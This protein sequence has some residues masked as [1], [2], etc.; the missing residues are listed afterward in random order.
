MMRM[1]LR[2]EGLQRGRWVRIAVLGVLFGLWSFIT[3][4]GAE[5]TETFCELEGLTV[6]AM[7]APEAADGIVAA[8]PADDVLVL[9]VTPDTRAVRLPAPDA[10]GATAPLPGILIA[11]VRPDPPDPDPPSPPPPPPPPPRCGEPPNPPCGPCPN[12]PC[13]PP[14]PAR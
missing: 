12:P 5:M 10:V 7:T 11:G 13:G 3:L 2:R 4:A 8:V 1:I 14:S 9:A 6:V